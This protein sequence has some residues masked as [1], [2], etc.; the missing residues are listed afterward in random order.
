MRVVT[1]FRFFLFDFLFI[2]VIMPLS[3]RRGEG[4][5]REGGGEDSLNVN[6]M[7]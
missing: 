2:D 4:G 3:S 6:G 1:E 5:E 7:A